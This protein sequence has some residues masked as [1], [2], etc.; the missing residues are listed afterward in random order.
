MKIAKVPY[1]DGREVLVG[2]H[3][4]AIHE[5]RFRKFRSIH[6]LTHVGQ[7]HKG[8]VKKG[9]TFMLGLTLENKLFAVAHYAT[10]L[11][12]AVTPLSVNLYEGH[13]ITDY[14]PTQRIVAIIEGYIGALYSALEVTAL[15]NKCFDKNLPQGFRRQAKKVEIFSLEKHAWLRHFY[16]VRSEFAHYNSPLPLVAQQKLIIEFRNPSKLEIFP[17]GRHEIAFDLILNYASEL[18]A[19][20]DAWALNELKNVDENTELNVLHETGWKKPLESRNITLK[21]LLAEL[22]I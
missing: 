4:L 14:E 3:N 9:D 16:D 18:F 1:E 12:E 6:V 20:L 22:G 17:K 11:C 13:Y 8:T 21:T 19:M 7:F 15:L 10:L 2:M 5:A